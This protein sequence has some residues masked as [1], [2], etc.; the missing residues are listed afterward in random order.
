[1]VTSWFCSLLIPGLSY[2]SPALSDPK[3]SG[4]W[5]VYLHV[6]SLF[7]TSLLVVFTGLMWYATYKLAKDSNRSITAA[8]KA[9]EAAISAQRAWVKVDVKATH[10]LVGEDH[11]QLEVA[12][13]PTN[14]GKTPA[15]HVF[16]WVSPSPVTDVDGFR[17]HDVM[18][19]AR[20]TVLGFRRSREIGITLF[21]NDPYFGFEAKAV[22]VMNQEL[23]KAGIDIKRDGKPINFTCCGIVSYKFSGGSGETPFILSV[24]VRSA[25]SG[26]WETPVLSV[27]VFSAQELT[28]IGRTDGYPAI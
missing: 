27:Q 14:V 11:I 8:E 23:V 9:A 12:L 13:T 17:I 21:P 20:D 25:S 22:C 18:K 5:A 1:M 2:A 16:S 15:T 26:R 24:L 28:L 10:F 3:P 19:Q 7:I 4:W 6:A